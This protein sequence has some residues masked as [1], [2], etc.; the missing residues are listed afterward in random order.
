MQHIQEK[1]F[2]FLLHPASRGKN[3]PT[4]RKTGGEK[5]IVIRPGC[6]LD[7]SLTHQHMHIIRSQ[8]WLRCRE[9]TNQMLSVSV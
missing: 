2:F 8:I 3:A 7:G 5:M 1:A 6:T 4:L 9:L